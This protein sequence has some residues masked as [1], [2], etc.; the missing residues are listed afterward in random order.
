[1]KSSPSQA[2]V[3]VNDMNE[4]TYECHHC[5]YETDCVDTYFYRHEKGGGFH[6]V[7]LCPKCGKAMKCLMMVYGP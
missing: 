3:W 7:P 1:M 5:G 6:T 4:E 2:E